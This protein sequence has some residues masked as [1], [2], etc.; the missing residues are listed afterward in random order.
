MV[1]SALAQAHRAPGG[2]GVALGLCSNT[3]QPTPPTDFTPAMLVLEFNLPPSQ[4]N[5]QPPQSP[6]SQSTR[7]DHTT[8]SERKMSVAH[9]CYEE[10]EIQ[11]VDA[12]GGRGGSVAVSASGCDLYMYML[13]A[14]GGCWGAVGVGLSH[15]CVVWGKCCFYNYCTVVTKRPVET[16]K[17][18]CM[19]GMRLPQT[20]R[21]ALL[22]R[23]CARQAV[24][25]R[26]ALK[27]RHCSAL[28]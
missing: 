13:R 4:Q 26:R 1:G 24:R 16:V 23:E 14:V 22:G 6:V 8:A 10:Q 5:S 9:V 11:G 3:A 19:H 28:L 2:R 25:G 27:S 21:R 20:A 18:Q 15:A 7:A 12:H 17:L